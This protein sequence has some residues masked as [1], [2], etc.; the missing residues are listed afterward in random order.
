[1]C[2]DHIRLDISI[3]RG[4]LGYGGPAMLP[5]RKDIVQLL[6]VLI[7]RTFSERGYTGTGRLISRILHTVSAVY[8]Y[9]SRFVNQ[10]LWDSEGRVVTM[11]ARCRHLT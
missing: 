10:D 3:L 6:K 8:P 4:C 2:A 5:Y 7:D 11:R 1:M 9:D